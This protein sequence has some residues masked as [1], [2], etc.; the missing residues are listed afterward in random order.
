MQHC[1]F[2]DLGMDL[3]GYV[4][5]CTNVIHN[6]RGFSTIQILLDNICDPPP[7]NKL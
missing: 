4:L 5:Y 6:A 3:L 1:Y 7:R 2:H